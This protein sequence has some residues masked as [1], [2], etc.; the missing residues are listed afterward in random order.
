MLPDDDEPKEMC[1]AHPDEA[2][3]RDNEREALPEVW[4]KLTTP[5]QPELESAPALRPGESW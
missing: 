2:S 1:D 3:E 5:G 4:E